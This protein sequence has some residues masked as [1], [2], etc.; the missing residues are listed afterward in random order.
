MKKYLF[1]LPILNIIV[2][3]LLVVVAILGMFVF[4]W[5]G[6][7]ANIFVGA[8]IIIYTVMRFYK[9]RH[10]YKNS[11]ALM[12]LT[13]EA[14]IAITLSVLLIFNQL[15][16]TFTLG[17]ALYMRGFV[18]LLILQLL[19]LRSEFKMFIIYLLLL[20]FGA[21]LL[22]GGPNLQDLIEWIIFVVFIAYGIVMIVFGVDKLR[23]K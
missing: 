6:E 12:I 13:V 5:F 11:N 2:G 3:T 17:L 23:K 7:A 9:E 18:Y 1:K 4:D 14:I 20:T 8:L 21:Y 16:L 22:F 19:K 15:D 10:N